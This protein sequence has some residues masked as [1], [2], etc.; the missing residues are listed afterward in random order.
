MGPTGYPTGYPTQEPVT[1][2]NALRSAFGTGAFN[3]MNGTNS[4]QSTGA[5]TEG[6]ATPEVEAIANTT[7]GVQTSG[8]SRNGFGVAA[9]LAAYQCAKIGARAVRSLAGCFRNRKNDP[10]RKD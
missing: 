1:G 7:G 4:T 2:D 9:G 6:N 10:K 8:A 5:L 3:T